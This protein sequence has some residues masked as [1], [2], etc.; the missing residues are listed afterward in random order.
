MTGNAVGTGVPLIG[1]LGSLTVSV[2]GR[3]VVPTA[4]R[5]RTMLAVLA[6][7]A[8]EPVPIGRLAAAVWG[9]DPPQD[10]RRTTQVYVARLRRL[11]GA[12]LIRTVPAGYAL[13]VEPDNVDA[14]LF[15]RLVD[16]AA[17]ATEP[18]TERALL[19]AALALW[20]GDPFQDAR[21]AWLDRVEAPRLVDRRL[22]ALERRIELDLADPSPAL[23]AE[24]QGLT[25][26]YPLRERFWAS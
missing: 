22:A 13:M 19:V 14:R 1:V 8:G 2:R 18:D 24:L 10:V 25:A 12:E 17:R 4:S 20:R 15:V 3:P 7:A 11:L 26:R 23:V 5:L 6:L 16:A 9:D 21:S